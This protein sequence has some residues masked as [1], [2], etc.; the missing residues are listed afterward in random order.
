[1]SDGVI[2][3]ITPSKRGIGNVRYSATR[4]R[5]VRFLEGLTQVK[6]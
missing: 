2:A 4:W 6:L 5:Y 1:M 3:T